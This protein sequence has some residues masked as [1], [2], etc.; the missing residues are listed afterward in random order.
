MYRGKQFRI[1]EL[2]ETLKDLH[3]VSHPI[4]DRVDKIFVADGDALVLPMD[5]WRQILKSAKAGFGRLRQVSCYALADNVLDKSVDQLRELREGGLNLLYIG[6]ESGD[7]VTLKR[8]VKGADH[9]AHIKAAKKAH[10]AGMEISVIVLL[11]V[12]GTARSMDHA[13][14][15]A[16]LITGM[17]PEYLAALTV[18]V[19]PGTPLYRMQQ[20]GRFELPSIEGMLIEL[21]TIVDKS[22]PS[23]AV[24]RTNHASNYLP[25]Q[26]DLPRDR[27]RIVQTID[28]ALNGEISLREEWMRGL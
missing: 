27:E 16:D 18:T 23:S 1:R 17:D 12:A 8:I 15:T 6:P 19:L 10:E 7:D 11:G 26:G 2:S 4:G 9:T 25:L 21:R 22:R 14:A 24:F 28:A 3:A 5:H 20:K 13:E